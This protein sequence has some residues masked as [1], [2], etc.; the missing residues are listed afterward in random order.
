ML[1]LK[2]LHL[3]NFCQYKDHTFD[4]SKNKTIYPFVC[5]FGPNGSGKSTVLEAISLLTC[6]TAGLKLLE[7]GT[8]SSLQKFIRSEDCDPT[9]ASLKNNH[10][11]MLVEG[12][13]VDGKTEYKVKLTEKGFIKNDFYSVDE[14]GNASSPW[15]DHLRY[16]KRI[17]Q[18]LKSDSNLLR[19]QLHKSFKSEFEQITEEVMR[20]KVE[21]VE[22]SEMTEMKSD[23]YTDLI[24]HKNNQ[25][26]HYKRLSQGEK[27]ICKSFSEMLNLIASLQ[28][29]PSPMMG[30]PRILLM[31]EIESHVYYD[32]HVR[33]INSLKSVFKHQQIFATTHSGVLVPNFKNGNYDKETEK[34][35]DLESIH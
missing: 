31:D 1:S 19:F 23:F 17:C 33:F 12:I 10:E 3:K 2:S 16:R 4:F 30:W 32:R 15:D 27:K 21:C 6:E 24:L 22:L 25:R 11:N 35:F 18:Y 29:G 28:S 8:I 13:Y 14:D 9:Y 34:W 5:F 20:Y 26:V 7:D